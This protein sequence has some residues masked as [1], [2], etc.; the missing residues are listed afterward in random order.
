[1]KWI[2][3]R[4]LIPLT[5]SLL[6][7]YVAWLEM[8]FLFLLLAIVFFLIFFFIQFQIYKSL[9]IFL[10][11]LIIG[12]AISEAFL[13]IFYYDS[14]TSIEYKKNNRN[15]K[16]IQ[17]I[18]GI[19]YKAYPGNYDVKKFSNKK[20]LIYHVSYS[21][22]LDGYRANISDDPF[23]A[24]IYGGSFTFGEGL[25]DNETLSAHLYNE[26]KINTKNMGL[27]GYG[28]NHALFNI[29]SDKTESNSINILLTFPAH[30]LRSSCKPAYSKG[31]PLYKKIGNDAIYNGSCPFGGLFFKV[32]RKS[33][34]Y[35]LVQEAFYDENNI[36]TDSDIDLY[37]SIINEIYK[38]TKDKDSH[39]IIAYIKAPESQL[40]NTSWTNESIQNRLRLISDDIVDVS[41][42]N[43]MNFLD[44]KYTLHELDTHPS[45]LANMKRAELLSDKINKYKNF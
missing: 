36:I 7:F 9:L 30:A 4:A 15:A 37:I 6:L 32:I 33:Y 10:I 43:D 3:T 24:Y 14:K 39:L 12:F 42:A 41:L 23:N 19:G 18:N 44:K 8:N 11:S 1:M 26:Y 35:A 5:F 38:N 22:G 13:Q 21:I 29:T 34:V 20:E 2:K 45:S 28:L 16:L 40:E 31:S 17:S 25:N 27:G